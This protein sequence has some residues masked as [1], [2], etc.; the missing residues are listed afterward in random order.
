MQPLIL[1]SNEPGTNH[2]ITYPIAKCSP[3]GRLCPV[4][5]NHWTTGLDHDV[6]ERP[7]FQEVPFYFFHIF[8]HACAC[9]V[10]VCVCVCMCMCACACVCVCV[11]VCVRVRV[12]VCVCVCACVR[13]C[14][15]V[16]CA[17]VCVCVRVCV[18]MCVCMN[19][20]MCLKL[21]PK[22]NP[23]SWFRILHY[24]NVTSALC[25][26]L[27]YKMS[28]IIILQCQYVAIELKFILA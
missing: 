28:I 26:F 9:C 25:F 23:K 4:V 27:C 3:A 17:C 13:V 2:V 20:Y 12:C 5:Y 8:L 15:C 24:L 6:I 22:P 14:V 18:C 21:F 19:M 1:Y 7:G 16:C 11:C 10:C